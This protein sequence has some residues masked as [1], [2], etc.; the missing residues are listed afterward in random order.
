M[1]LIE[2]NLPVGMNEVSVIR[3]S[4]G[5]QGKSGWN[6]RVS[7]A[8]V[9]GQTHGWCKQT[10]AVLH[11]VGTRP[12][13]GA[14]PHHECTGLCGQWSFPPGDVTRDVHLL[15][16]NGSTQHRTPGGFGKDLRNRQVQVLP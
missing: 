3:N 6:I 14:G 13:A 12:E 10:S 4:L 15:E 8:F 11:G 9:L 2:I 1:L 7:A 16:G 5:E